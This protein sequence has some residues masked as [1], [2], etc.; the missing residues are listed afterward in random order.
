LSGDCSRAEAS[1]I[2]RLASAAADSGLMLLAT[3]NQV[4]SPLAIPVITERAKVSSE[5]SLLDMPAAPR[6]LIS[7][8]TM[9]ALPRGV[10]ALSLHAPR[11]RRA[12]MTLW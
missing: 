11:Q 5:S 7:D 2:S 6:S 12:R 4:L 10:H 1:A 9:S 3:N 8:S